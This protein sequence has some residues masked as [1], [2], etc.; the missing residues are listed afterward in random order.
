MQL[1]FGRYRG[2]NVEDVPHSYLKWLRRQP[3]VTAEL[4]AG[5]SAALG[6][7]P[8]GGQVHHHR[9]PMI[10]VKARASGERD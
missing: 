6:I 7:K 4:K 1:R 3:G 10:D 8:K 5:I 9:P 2:L